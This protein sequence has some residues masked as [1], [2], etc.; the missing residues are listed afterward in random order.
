MSAAANRATRG[1]SEPLALTMMGS[2]LPPSQLHAGHGV[3]HTEAGRRLRIMHKAGHS[4]NMQHMTACLHLWLMNRAT[5]PVRVASM[6]NTRLLLPDGSC[7]RTACMHSSARYWRVG[8]CK[9]QARQRQLSRCCA[10]ALARRLTSRAWPRPSRSYS[11]SRRRASPVVTCSPAYAATKAPRGIFS[12]AFTHQPCTRRH[13]HDGML[14]AARMQRWRLQVCSVARALC[15]RQLNASR[16]RTPCWLA[17][18]GQAVPQAHAGPHSRSSTTPAAR[19]CA[20]T[21]RACAA[22]RQGVGVVWNAL[23]PARA[24]PPVAAALCTSTPAGRAGRARA[25]SRSCTRRRRCSRRYSSSRPRLTGQP[26]L[27][28]S[29]SCTGKPSGPAH[30]P[31]GCGSRAWSNRSSGGESSLLLL[32]LQASAPQLQRQR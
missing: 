30:R 1:S 14:A 5:L 17:R 8:A 12:K 31:Q 24:R 23:P 10:A 13:E 22:A 27:Q 9:Q 6:A 18:A 26:V 3:C 20:C 19:P 11:A 32:L 15:W 16:K 4:A 29:R 2:R 7:T 28:Y 25:L 21:Q